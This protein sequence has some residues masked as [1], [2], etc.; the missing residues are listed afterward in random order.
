MTAGM[1]K[2][3]RCPS[4]TFSSRH[5]STECTRCPSGCTNLLRTSCRELVYPSAIPR[6]HCLAPPH[7]SPSS[8]IPLPICFAL[9]TLRCY[10]HI[11]GLVGQGIRSLA[12]QQSVLRS[13]VVAAVLLCT[14]S[15]LHYFAKHVGDRPRS[16]Y[17][18]NLAH[19]TVVLRAD[20]PSPQ[21][22]QLITCWLFDP[23]KRSSSPT[24][25]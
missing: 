10:L 6:P 13:N 18:I 19:R 2:C 9:H 5:A 20:Q 22:P 3:S 7:P 17:T 11:S 23:P 24:H 21:L 4:G 8:I 25:T 1:H 14:P 12:S 16:I 15:A